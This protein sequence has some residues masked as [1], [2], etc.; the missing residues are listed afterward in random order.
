MSETAKNKKSQIPPLPPRDLRNTESMKLVEQWSHMRSDVERR[1][2][3]T[4]LASLFAIVW[5]CITISNTFFIYALAWY[6]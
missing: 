6:Q 5:I 1:G 3:R 4:S 2:T